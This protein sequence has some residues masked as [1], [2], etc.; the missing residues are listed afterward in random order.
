MKAVYQRL[1]YVKFYHVGIFINQSHSFISVI[2]TV[3]FFPAWSIFDV[4]LVFSVCSISSV[5][6]VPA[7]VIYFTCYDQ[8]CA[9]L[10]VRMGD[11]S[12]EAPLLAGA[13]ARG[14]PITVAL[15]GK[16]RKILTCICR[17]CYKHHQQQ[18]VMMVCI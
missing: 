6:A 10:R 9:A 2:L 3:D 17:L 15:L 7:T 16:I 18:L 12:Q 8:L 4:T 1:I 13:I 5:M 14:E 11:Y